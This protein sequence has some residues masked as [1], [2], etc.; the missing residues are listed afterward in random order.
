MKM[1]DMRVYGYDSEGAKVHYDHNER[2]LEIVVTKKG[3]HAHTED[4]STFY[5]FRHNELA[6][7]T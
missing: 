5:D 6:V 4:E 2:D 3:I 1:P 7:I